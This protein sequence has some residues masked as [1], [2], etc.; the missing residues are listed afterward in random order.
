MYKSRYAARSANFR[1][2]IDQYSSITDFAEAMQQPYQRCF[3]W[4]YR[5]TIPPRYWQRLIRVERRHGRDL[6]AD[7]LLQMYAKRWK[8]VA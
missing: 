5:D 1:R 7:Q 3:R 2:L 8:D 6:S 4:R